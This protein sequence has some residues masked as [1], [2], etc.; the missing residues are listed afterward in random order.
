MR[1]VERPCKNG[2]TVNRPAGIAQIKAQLEQID[3]LEES[4]RQ[5]STS[6][7]RSSLWADR[8]QQAC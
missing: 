3:M 1:N 8:W 2:L 5:R 6:E 4:G 7:A